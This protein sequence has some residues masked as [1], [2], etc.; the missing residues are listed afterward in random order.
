M[1]PVTMFALL[2]TTDVIKLFVARYFLNKER[3]VQNLA[4][5]GEHTPLKR[6]AQ[7]EV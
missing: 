5:Q 6:H 2:K 7:D 4:A 1:D 3:W